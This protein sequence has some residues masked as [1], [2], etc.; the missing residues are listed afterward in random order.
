MRYALLLF[1]VTLTHGLCAQDDDC[2]CQAALED[3]WSELRELPA[4]RDRCRDDSCA[5][6]FAQLTARTSPEMSRLACYR[7]L[8]E[9]VATLLDGHTAIYGSAADTLGDGAQETG[10]APNN[11]LST[12]ERYYAGPYV[13]SLEPAAGTE[14]MVLRVV[15]SPKRRW[16]AGDTLAYLDPLG[17]FRYRYTGYLPGDGRLV[18][19]QEQVRNGQ[20]HQLGLRR[21]TTETIFARYSGEATYAYQRVA[22]RVDYLRL[23]SFSGFQ[24]VL[25]EAEA[26]YATLSDSLTGDQLIVDLRDNTG[27]GVRNSNIVYKIL[28]RHRRHYD[29][30]YVLINH[31]TTSNAEQFA[32]RLKRW[33]RVVTAGEATKGVLAYELQGESV[34]VGCDRYLLRMATKRHRRYL[35]YE[36]KG[37]PAEIELLHDRDWVEQLR[38]WITD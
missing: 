33:S 23:G 19:F 7:L 25:G 18:T 35:P 1:L 34:S 31:G 30:I 21:D 36:G 37:V 22:T 27:G 10:A 2:S 11:D 6:R 9:L 16:Q 17:N 24:P 8:T 28:R 3:T 13:L 5:D 20:F 4:F 29:R 32:L 12:G 26:F 14:G 38:E 15:D